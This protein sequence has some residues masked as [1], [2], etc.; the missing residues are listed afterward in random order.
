MNFNLKR[1]HSLKLIKISI[2]GYTQAF[3]NKDSKEILFPAFAKAQK[4]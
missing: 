2:L 4:K 3:T 1:F